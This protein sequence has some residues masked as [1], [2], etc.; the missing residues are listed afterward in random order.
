MLY[1]IVIAIVLA[2][3][4]YNVTLSVL[5]RK[6]SHRAIPKLLED[7]YDAGAYRR[8]QSYSREYSR[9]GLF[10]TSVDTTLLLGLFAFGGFAWFDSVARSVSDAPIVMALV[11]FGIFFLLDWAVG[12]PF[13]VYS[14][15]HIEERYG[16]NRTTPLLFLTD[17]L[18]G[19][20]VSVVLYGL[21]I[22]VVVWIYSLT[23]AYFWLIA[24]AVL[25]VITLVLQF[26]Y[27]DVIVPL[28]NK[29]TPLAEGELRSAIEAFARQVGFKLDNIYVI[30]G[31][32][33]SSKANA[34]FTGFGT[35]KRV[36]LYDTLMEQLSTDEI[37]AVLAHE[38]GHYKHRHIWKGIVSALLQNLVM[39]YL[40][41]L[42]IDSREIAEAARCTMPSFHINMTVFMLL[43]TPIQIVTSL[44]GNMV[45][46]RHE[47]QADEFARLH[48]MGR[49]LSSA[50]K[51]MSAK[52]LANLTPHPAVVFT[53]YSHPTL[54]QRVE[55]LEGC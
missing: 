39:F 21:L 51:N 34:Y 25:S 52:S 45:S 37:V 13:S 9:L 55:H 38:I 40:F 53:Q 18:K 3:Y 49:A 1:W 19:L 26:F 46:R 32:K 24:W 43:F 23:P 8:Q 17:T 27:S 54:L 16:F 10:S 12:L 31:S 48:G 47:W 22:S 2:E 4:I 14:T 42:I 6:A 28:F 5:G 20:A 29:Q 7:I 30:D 11:Y 36:V 35:R 44:L 15:F 33:R 50:L 41:G